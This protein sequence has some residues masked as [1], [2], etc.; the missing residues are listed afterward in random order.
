MNLRDYFDRV[1]LINLERRPERRA[2][3]LHTLSLIDWPFRAP[4]IFQAFDGS[5]SAVPTGWKAS[6][7]AWG[8][9]RSHQMVLEQAIADG[10]SNVLV[11]EDDVCFAS[12][13]RTR[14]E[15]FLI[16]LPQDWDQLMIGGQHKTQFGWPATVNVSVTRTFACEGTHCYA[17]RGDYM[18]R[19]VERWGGGGLLDGNVHCDWIMARDPEM[20]RAHKVYSPS[21][22]LAGQDRGRSD[23]ASLNRPRMFWNP[24]APELPLV[25]LACP[26]DVA[27]EL[28]EYGFFYGPE[29]DAVSDQ[30]RKLGERIGARGSDAADVPELLSSFI[31]ELQWQVASEPR[32]LATIVCPG[33]EEG[34]L[35]DVSLWQVRSIRAGSVPEA[36]EQLPPALRRPRMPLLADQAILHYK[37]PRNVLGAMCQYG[38]Q[39]GHV[40]AASGE[41]W[42]ALEDMP[43]AYEPRQRE[44]ADLVERL[45]REARGI[46]SGIGVIWSPQVTTEELRLASPIQVIEVVAQSLPEAIHVW[47]KTK[48]TL[49]EPPAY[50]R[51]VS[52]K[53]ARQESFPGRAHGSR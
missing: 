7:G 47:E 14:I 33:V 10:I 34:M 5:T 21:S 19:L 46:T 35:R 40:C 48:L 18:R 13:F 28:K 3:V 38:W 45:R 51:C 37:G 11:L 29:A 26:M 42:R 32:L 24:P 16:A 15:E 31:V 44:I 27:E 30:S 52:L 53:R 25:H 1:V 12:N 41:E 2:R 22:F 49:D 23:V 43:K 9:L 4:E 39:S 20:Q 50:D 8:C 17:I 36:L 6:P